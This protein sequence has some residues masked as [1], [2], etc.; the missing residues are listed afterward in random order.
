MRR[1]PRQARLLVKSMLERGRAANARCWLGCCNYYRP[2]ILDFG[3]M[4]R[5]I[6]DLTTDKFGKNIAEE[7]DSD[8]KYQQAFDTLKKKL[9]SYPILRL[10]D[11]SKPYVVYRTLP[12]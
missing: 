2:Y 12:V 3:A 9:C 5:P 6:I 8:P 1:G 11:L 10:P 7:W 4:A